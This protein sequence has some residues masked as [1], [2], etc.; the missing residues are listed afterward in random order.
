MKKIF[1]FF[2]IIF[3]INSSIAADTKNFLLTANPVDTAI[4]FYEKNKSQ[5]S[6]IPDG[7]GL[8]LLFHTN[9]HYYLIAGPRSEKLL[10]LNGGK[11]EHPDL[12]LYKQLQEELDEE[13]FD[14]LHL[15]TSKKGYD[16]QILSTSYALTLRNDVS[17]VTDR[18]GAFTYLTFT[19]VVDEV[20]L[21][22]ILSLADKVSPTAKFWS[23]L[24]N[25]LSDTVRN[26]PKDDSFK[27]YWQN[28]L[29]KLNQVLA[30]MTTLYNELNSEG[31]LLIS[32]QQAFNVNNL[33]EA[34]DVVRNMNTYTEL[35]I[36]FS[37]NVGR[38]SERVGYYVF[39]ANSLLQSQKNKLAF[40]DLYGE[41]IAST[42]F[43]AP[44][45][46]LVF[47]EIING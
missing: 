31:K 45:V 23:K 15:L 32:P 14:T 2:L 30:E 26:A 19:A 13:L 21:M 18:P 43:N 37:N 20:P 44:A 34:W 1:T 46:E 35:K 7:T 28:Q 6:Q 4:R 17:L 9:Q 24:G 5:I 40:T 33:D 8:Q 27:I 22:T 16:I 47:P 10:T 25:Y 42:L 39:D 12:P 38:Y 29:P 36:F 41:E 3:S 11:I